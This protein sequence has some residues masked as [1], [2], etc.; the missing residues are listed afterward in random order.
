MVR[1]MRCGVRNAPDGALAAVWWRCAV[2]RGALQVA[3]YSMC[4]LVAKMCDCESHTETGSGI[5]RL[6]P[7]FLGFF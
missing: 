6:G 7:F 5:G 1:H 4:D 2:R 3:L